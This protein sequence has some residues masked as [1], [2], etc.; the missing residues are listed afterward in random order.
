MTLPTTVRRNDLSG[1]LVASIIESRNLDCEANDVVVSYPMNSSKKVH[2]IIINND[3][4]VSLYMLDVG[5]DG[6]W[7]I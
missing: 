6:F 4:C 5:A 1:D 3:R 7:P 2:P